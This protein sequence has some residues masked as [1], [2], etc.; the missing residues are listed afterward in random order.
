M[1]ARYFFIFMAI[2]LLVGLFGMRQNNQTAYDMWG[3]IHGDTGETAER[4]DYQALQ[5][6]VHNNMNAS[7]PAGMDVFR[8]DVYEGALEEYHQAIAEESSSG[9]VYEDAVAECDREGQSATDNAECVQNYIGARLGDADR[10]TAAEPNPEDFTTTLHSPRWTPDLAGLSLLG[11][12]L[13]GLIGA[14]LY[15]KSQFRKP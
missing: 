1:K 11:A 4:E 14:V 2:L 12:V 8:R 15:A 3:D 6:Y 13:S 9:T 7:G 5:E 10:Q